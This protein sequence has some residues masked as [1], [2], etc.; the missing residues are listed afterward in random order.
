MQYQYCRE[1]CLK[2]GC[3]KRRQLYQCKK[4]RKYQRST[5]KLHRVTAA[6]KEMVAA[7]ISEGL[8]ISS[9]SRLL[10]I[11][12]STVLRIITQLA[13][14]IKLPEINEHNQ[15]Y[16]VD[17]LYTY[18]CNKTNGCWIMYAINKITKR[19]ID[20]TVGKRTKE[21][22]QRVIDSLHRLN[23]KRIYTD[24]LNIYPALIEKKKH[25]TSA[26]LIN[27]IERMNVNLRK[28][29]KCL[30]RKTI[31]YSKSEKMLKAKLMVYFF[32]PIFLD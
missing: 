17:E 2:K 24:R 12:R 1:A 9:I 21:N 11:A 5:Y 14:A 15:E 16:E 31:C 3:Y 7:F 8:S 22:I 20:F 26:H 4:C 28:D 29:I 27:H 25:K 6:K 10:K 32:N 30:N 19:V 13:D 18:T 23:P